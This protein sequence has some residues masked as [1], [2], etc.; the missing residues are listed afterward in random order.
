MAWFP[1][2]TKHFTKWDDPPSS[3]IILMIL[4]PDILIASLLNMRDKWFN[5]CTPETCQPLWIY[6]LDVII[7]PDLS[8]PPPPWENKVVYDV[9]LSFLCG[10]EPLLMRSEEFEH[11]KQSIF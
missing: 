10:E 8:T 3:D 6:I 4:V 2:L 7:Y 9:S 11:K 5:W 1:P